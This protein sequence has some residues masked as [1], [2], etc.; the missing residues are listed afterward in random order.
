M[1]NIFDRPTGS[2]THRPPKHLSKA[3]KVWFKK[4]VATWTLDDHHVKLLVSACEALDRAE[5][6]RQTLEKDGTYFRNHKGDIV[7]H[8]A[9]AVEHNSRI[10]FARLLRELD[11]DVEAPA[12]ASRPPQLR[13]IRGGNN[14]T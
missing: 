14:A 1:K 12:E 10:V 9:F 11:L 2:K 7:R 13:S 5:E 3:S 6:A 8:P 4:V